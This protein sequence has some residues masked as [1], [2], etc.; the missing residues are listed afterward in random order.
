[1]KGFYTTKMHWNSITHFPY[2]SFV[3]RGSDGSE[4]LA[5]LS[6]HHMG[7]MLSGEPHQMINVENIYRQSDVHPESLAPVGYGDGGGGITREQLERV[8]RQKDLYGEPRTRFGRTADYFKRLGET[9]ESLPLY[10]GELYLEYHRGVFTSRRPIKK[11]YR[12]LERALQTGEAVRAA[13]DGRT[14]WFR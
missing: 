7:Y 10:E 4:L 2:S 11:A 12:A 5:H 13:T 3:W 8:R 9:R 6:Q 14:A 1:M